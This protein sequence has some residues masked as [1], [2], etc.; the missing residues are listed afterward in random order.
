M[1]KFTRNGLLL[2]FAMVSLP[3]TA[4]SGAADVR[5][6]E[7]GPIDPTHYAGV[8]VANGMIGLL[9]APEPFRLPQTLIA[10]AYEPEAKR[11]VRMIMR[12]R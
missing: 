10:G 4:E 11:G 7:S 1:R 2:G 12:E 9:S 5:T 8:T 6:L 3:A